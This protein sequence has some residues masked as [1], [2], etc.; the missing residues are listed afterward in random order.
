MAATLTDMFREE[1]LQLDGVGRHSPSR[2]FSSIYRQSD[3]AGHIYF[4]AAGL[5]KLFNRD[6]DGKEVILR[7]VAPGEWFGAE[8]LTDSGIRGASAEILQEAVVF[9]IPRAIL[10][11]FAESRPALW[12]LLAASLVARQRQA[13]IKIEML[14]MA[15]VETRILYFIRDLAR[16]LKQEGQS[17]EFMIPLS[18]GELA[19]LIGATRE[20]T[21]TTLNMLARKGILRLGRRLLIVPSLDAPEPQHPVEAGQPLSVCAQAGS[22]Q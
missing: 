8:A 13:E 10:A 14:C 7:I 18:Q 11:S 15:D 4:V 6:K 9:A 12:P 16:R 19:S 22:R 17:T 3:P 21:S 1:I 5:I 2:R 20:T